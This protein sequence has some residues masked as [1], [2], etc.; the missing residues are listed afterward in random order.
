M[1]GITSGDSKRG[2]PPSRMIH[3]TSPFATGD[4]L[5]RSFDTAGL[6]A[7]IMTVITPVFSD[8]SHDAGTAIWFANVYGHEARGPA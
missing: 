7:R 5:T 3:P 8:Y 1:F 6:L 4:L 2:V